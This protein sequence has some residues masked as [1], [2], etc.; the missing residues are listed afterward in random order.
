MFAGDWPVVAALHT[1]ESEH[2][3][4]IL[5]L[6]GKIVQRVRGR[7][8]KVR[9]I[10]RGDSGFCREELM[11]WC[12]AC[13]IHYVLGLARN[14]VLERILRGSLRMA[15]SMRELYGSTTE[16]VCKDFRYRAKSWG[17][18]R[19]RVVGKAEWARKAMAMRIPQ[20]VASD[21]DMAFPGP[22]L[23]RATW[24]VRRPHFADRD[25]GRPHQ[26]E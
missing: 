22:L 5:R 21:F 25:P 3:E 4:E 19:W 11:G 20:I 1:A 26:T 18:A 8:P 9:L 24:L 17:R 14:A 15:R 16:R 12:E 6:L 2:R 10:L 23:P 13:H 7:F